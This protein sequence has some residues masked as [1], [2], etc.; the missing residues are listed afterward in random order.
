[1]LD[2]VRTKHGPATQGQG[3]QRETLSLRHWP[4][5]KIRVS[6]RLVFVGKVPL[7]AVA[8]TR[9]CLNVGLMLVQRLRRWPNIKTTL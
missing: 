1:M 4:N 2:V 5:I 6:Q 8:N 7:L 9:H 3:T